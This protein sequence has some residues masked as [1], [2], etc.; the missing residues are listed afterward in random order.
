MNIEL[1]PTVTSLLQQD[2][3]T[4]SGDRQLIEKLSE[5]MEMMLR[6]PS[7]ANRSAS[8][9]RFFPK[10]HK[11]PIRHKLIGSIDRPL[12]KQVIYSIKLSAEHIELLAHIHSEHDVVEKAVFS[13]TLS[14]IKDPDFELYELYS[15]LDR[16]PVFTICQQ[17]KQLVASE[18]CSDGICNGIKDGNHG[19]IAH[20][21]DAHQHCEA[22]YKQVFD[23]SLV[24]RLSNGYCYD[25][26]VGVYKDVEAGE[27]KF[28]I[29]VTDWPHPHEPVPSYLVLATLPLTASVKEVK[30]LKLKLE[31]E[32]EYP[33]P[34]FHCKEQIDNAGDGMDLDSFVDFKTEAKLCY[35]CASIHYGV[36]Y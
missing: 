23:T 25:G 1:I 11:N 18:L 17:C 9:S 4:V 15:A 29:S 28:Y 22:T 36:V 20:N 2:A 27:V 12:T 6:L 10:E 5:H 24:D 30:S 26:N 16:S 13:K 14:N 33:A 21:S 8:R 34:C 35:G 31:A 32:Q 3:I 19:L 7:F